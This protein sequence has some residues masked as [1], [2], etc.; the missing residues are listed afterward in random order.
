MY[1][2]RPDRS[3]QLGHIRQP[4]VARLKSSVASQLWMH[5]Q[6]TL[7]DNPV[8]PIQACVVSDPQF[9]YTDSEDMLAES[10][11]RPSHAVHETL[12]KTFALNDASDTL[13]DGSVLHSATRDAEEDLLFDPLPYEV[14]SDI[15][16]CGDDKPV[17]SYF[18][19]G[20]SISD[21]FDVQPPAPFRE[22]Q[23]VYEVSHP[24]ELAST[25]Y[26]SAM[27]DSSRA[28]HEEC[29]FEDYEKHVPNA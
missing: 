26:S 12:D 17:S 24:A 15:D 19:T 22:T 1:R 9:V 20:L 2:S 23:L 4:D 3:H 16:S 6:R 28:L 10:S 13:D 27:N 5:S 11:N 21:T 18:R 29:L 8:P 7:F 14:M 25:V